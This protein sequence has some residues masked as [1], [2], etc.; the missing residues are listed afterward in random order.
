MNFIDALQLTIKNL[1]LSLTLRS[2][3]AIKQKKVTGDDAI[4]VLDRKKLL[5]DPASLSLSVSL[6]SWTS[7]K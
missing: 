3:I 1:N 6:S 5:D 7:A 4:G 2:Q